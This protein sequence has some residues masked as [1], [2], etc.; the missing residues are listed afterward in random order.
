MK[1]PVVL[2][3]IRTKYQHNMCAV[4]VRLGGCCTER[5]LETFEAVEGVQLP[6]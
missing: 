2:K 6:K 4:S 3:R 1:I 5:S